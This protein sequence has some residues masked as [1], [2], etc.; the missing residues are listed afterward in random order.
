VCLSAN[1]LISNR[2]FAY[3]CSLDLSR[4]GADLLLSPRIRPVS[5]S[6]SSAHSQFA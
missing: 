3:K 6:D 5:G 2:D 1:L 4:D